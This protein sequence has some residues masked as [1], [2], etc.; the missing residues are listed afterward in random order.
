MPRHKPHLSEGD[1]QLGVIGN[2]VSRPTR[3]HSGITSDAKLDQEAW[4]H[5]VQD[6]VRKEPALDQLVHSHDT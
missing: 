4:Q 2:L 6:L 1:V 5:T 3:L